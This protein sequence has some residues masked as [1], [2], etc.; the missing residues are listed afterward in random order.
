MATLHVENFPDDLHE[1]IQERA[2]ENRT[3]MSAVVT[4]VLSHVIPTPAER[5]RRA[6]AVR[7][8]LELRSQPSP[9]PGPFPSTE[10]MVREDRER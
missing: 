4:D 7:S 1:A 6:E 9:G 10:E 8:M 5:E 3:T 2:R